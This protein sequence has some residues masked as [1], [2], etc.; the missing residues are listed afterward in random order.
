M[1]G[2]QSK[3]PPSPKQQPDETAPFPTPTGHEYDAIDKIASELP[4]VIDEE[5]KQ[6]VEDYKQACDNGKGTMVACFA[7]A[8]FISSFERKHQEAADLY[9]N[10]C[11]RPKHD[12]SPGRVE[13]DNSN[14]YPAGCFN[15]GKMYMTGKGVKP[16]QWQ[17]YQLVDRACRGG[18][19]GACFL[20]AQMLCAQPGAFGDKV[21]HDPKKAMEL[22]QQTCDDG[23]SVSCYTLATML[24]RGDRVSK[25]ANN[26]SPQEA[27]GKAPIAQREA[28]E[29]RRSTNNEPYVIQRDP[30]RAEQLLK[31]GCDRGG[32]VTSCHNL[33]VMYTHG[34]D[35][36]A[37]NPQEAE[38]YKQRTKEKLDIF[39][40]F[41]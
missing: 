5:S 4:T 18:H 35:G 41:Q 10:V 16:D 19:G 30:V 25:T 15:L 40:G 34:D 11:F 20:Q 39:G 7:T 8:E 36:V 9:K 33:A 29:D 31:V 28:E 17:G 21:P 12:K 13:V 32:H 14:S 27:R 23:D 22:Y 37:A 6:Q 2:T 26:V 38:V 3:Q 24:L 1:G